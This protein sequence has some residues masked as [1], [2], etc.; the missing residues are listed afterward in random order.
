MTCWTSCEGLMYVM[1]RLCIPWHLLKSGFIKSCFGRYI[2]ISFLK[3]RNKEICCGNF[4]CCV[5]T[6]KDLFRIKVNT[7]PQLG[8][9]DMSQPCH[10]S[11]CKKRYSF[12]YTTWLHDKEPFTKCACHQWVLF[13]LFL[14]ALNTEER[15]CKCVIQTT[16]TKVN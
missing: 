3:V 11:T 16:Q 1:F 10:C 8:R 9:L 2:R 13:Q 15:N 12:Y 6:V 14:I 5:F 7:T 4:L